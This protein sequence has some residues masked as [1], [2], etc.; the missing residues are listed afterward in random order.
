[1]FAKQTNGKISVLIAYVDD[2]VLARNRAEARYR[3][4]ALG[5]CEFL[6]LWTLLED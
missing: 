6:G 5:V 4:I 3:A 1:M 2:I